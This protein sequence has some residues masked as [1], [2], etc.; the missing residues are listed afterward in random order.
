M[1]LHLP[2]PPWPLRSSTVTLSR[3]PFSP[4]SLFGSRQPVSYQYFTSPRSP[5]QIRSI[6]NHPLLPTACPPCLLVSASASPRTPHAH[7]AFTEDAH[8]TMSKQYTTAEVSQHKD[9]AN[10]MWIIVD[11]GVY[12]ITSMP[13]RTPS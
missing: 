5:I 12:D 4:D 8:A 9:A 3:G 13:R 1:T 10:G 2:E 11:T 6:S 7:P